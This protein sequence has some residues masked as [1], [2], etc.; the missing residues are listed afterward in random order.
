MSV[1][2]RPDTWLAE[3]LGQPAAMVRAA[4]ALDARVDRLGVLVRAAVVRAGIY[5]STTTGNTSGRR[6]VCSYR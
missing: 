5:T 6:R 4:T 1:D 3:I 2:A